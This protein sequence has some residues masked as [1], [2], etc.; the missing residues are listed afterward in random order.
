MKYCLVVFTREPVVER[1]VNFIVQFATSLS[2]ASRERRKLEN[3]ANNEEQQ[4]EMDP[5]LLKLFKFLL[6]VI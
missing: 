3:E 5:F 2:F 1:M 6:K 4:D